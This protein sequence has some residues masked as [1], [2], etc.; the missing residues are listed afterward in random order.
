[1]NPAKI[2]VL[3]VQRDRVGVV[4]NFLGEGIRQPSKA[5]HLHS[6]REV[7]LLNVRRDDV[8]GDSIVRN[9]FHFG[10]RDTSGAVATDRN[11]GISSIDFDELRVVYFAD[12]NCLNRFKLSPQPV[13][14]ELQAIDDSVGQIVD[15]LRGVCDISMA[16]LAR[17]DQLRFNLD[18]NPR[19]GIA[20]P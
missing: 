6:H 11:A 14:R 19:P 18:S 10:S 1:M 13:G 8:S 5:V 7:L 12:E 2:V 17:E 3:E 16:D 20:A 9:D 15:E 4:L